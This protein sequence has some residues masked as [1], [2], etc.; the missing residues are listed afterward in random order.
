MR[1][2]R[3]VRTRPRSGIAIAEVLSTVLMSELV[4]PSKELWLVSG[5]VSDISVVTNETGAF[6]D[7]LPDM[8]THT[9]KLSDV[10]VRL[11]QGGT[12]LRVAVRT[13]PHNEDFVTTLLRRVPSAQLQVFQ[14]PELHEK[15]L[16][17][18]DWVLRGSM[19]FTW[20]GLNINEES[21]EFIVDPTEAA[22]QR[23]ELDVRWR[24]NS[25]D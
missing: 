24:G 8:G 21:I 25:N 5:W 14:S 1:R 10:L 15:L 16:A 6:D 22:R 2:T 18:D 19:N 13:D 3:T 11:A 7:V 23:L 4:R 9:L 17:G 12:A 20:N